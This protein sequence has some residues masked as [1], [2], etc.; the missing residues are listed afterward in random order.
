VCR[1]VFFDYVCVLY[2]QQY[3]P[4][5]N[6]VPKPKQKAVA[7]RSAITGTYRPG[8]RPKKPRKEYLILVTDLTVGETIARDH[9]NIMGTET[10]LTSAILP[11]HGKQNVYIVDHIT[12]KKIRSFKRT[13]Y[14]IFWRYG[15]DGPIHTY[16]F[17][18]V[19]KE[20]DARARAELK[21]TRV[22][23]TSPAP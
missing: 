16:T 23:V 7:P 11:G 14:E 5:E 22:T 20:K 10:N 9:G 21:K 4:K 1:V 6:A 8:F 18:Q 15:D 3:N 12:L 2:G 13:G 19:L 17:K